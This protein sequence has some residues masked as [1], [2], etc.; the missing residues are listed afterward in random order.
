MHPPLQPWQ[1]RHGPP[2]QA[3]QYLGTDAAGQAVYGTPA[4]AGVAGAVAPLQPIKVHPWGAYLGGGCLAV[5]ALAVLGLIA[6]FLMIGLAI[7]AAVLALVAVA[8]TICVLV[9]R[10]MWRE[11]QR[12]KEW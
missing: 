2:L 5:I 6:F 8:L 1:P 12:E 11:Y 10:S 9:L 3:P 4:T 7:V